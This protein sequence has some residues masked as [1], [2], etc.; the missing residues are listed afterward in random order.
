MLKDKTIVLIE[1][2]DAA[3]MAPSLLTKGNTLEP[4]A[5]ECLGALLEE[6]GYNVVLIQQ[7]RLSDVEL[8]NSVFREA[9]ICVG[10]T[11]LTH[12]L[13]FILQLCHSI[14]KHN[15][16]IKIILGGQHPSLAPELVLHAAVDFMVLGEGELTFLELV[17]LIQRDAFHAISSLEGVAYKSKNVVI[18]NKRRN[19]IN[20]IDSLPRPLRFEKYL[21][22]S[23]SWNLTY[24]SP[25][26]QIGV[27]QITY[28]RGCK[29]ECFFC[30]SPIVWNKRSESG[31]NK[32]V[33]RKPLSVVKE[34]AAIKNKYGVNYFYFTD[35][36]F[37]ENADKTYE[38]CSE[39][40]NND[41]HIHSEE[42]AS[43][44]LNNSIHW[45][46]MVK[47]GLSKELARS[48]V[49]AGC[50]KIGIGIESFNQ[51]IKTIYRKPYKGH[52]E[53][54]ETLKN[55][56]AV[57]II[58]R[59]YL[60]IGS[61]YETHN[62]I[63]ETIEYLKKFKVDQIRIAYLTPY[64]GTPLY[65]KHKDHLIT[66]DLTY[67]DGEH[68]V[69]RPYSLSLNELANLRERISHEFYTSAEYV[70]RCADKISRFPWLEP[71][72]RYFFK[73]L[74]VKSKGLIDIENAVLSQLREDCSVC[75]T[76]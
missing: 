46:C 55:S 16:N 8:V 21:L 76:S 40:I 61:P 41:L 70:K 19:R 59:C 44:H 2:T 13:E 17:R 23:R 3:E 63:E 56:D 48:M 39:I 5:L 18:V 75:A 67:F 49:L 37:N 15:P 65:E 42:V 9:P 26:K 60:I 4:Y 38:L 71:S 33:Y 35:L 28:S 30:A 69:I 14:K 22:K 12:R 53:I 45:F 43:E 32:V 6:N 50:T 29:N 10:I 7:D 73:D 57:G 24:P 11:V 72:Y 74:F 27:A 64:P 62:S 54:E 52:K 58:N 68:P 66:N 36:T 34:I 31:N 25:D 1:P 47:V 20:D 51:S